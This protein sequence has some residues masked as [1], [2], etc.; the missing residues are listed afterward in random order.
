MNACRQFVCVL[1]LTVGASAYAQEQSLRPE[2]VL[3]A[4]YDH[5]PAILESLA[6]QRGAEA[7][8]LTAEGAFD[9]VFTGD[10]FSRVSGFYDGTVLTGG[11][12]RRLRSMGASVYANYRLSNGDFPIYEDVYFTNSGGE[13]R[14]GFLYSLL[15]DREIDPQRFGVRDAE[16][17]LE[18]AELDVM[19][20]RVGVQRQALIAYWRW[21]T[22]GR[23]LQVYENLLEIARNREA[24]LQ[25]EVD[26]GAR[27]AIF[28]TEN[29]QN[30]VRRQTLQTAAERDFRLATN[31]L[32][33]YYRDGGG[34]P[35]LPERDRLPPIG[36][37]SSNGE[38]LGSEEPISQALLRRPELTR[39]R[40]AIQRAQN[41][42]ALAENAQKPRLDLNVELD[43]DFGGIAEGGISRD[44]TDTKVG[45][46]FS[47]PLQLRQAR[48]QIDAANAEL[49]A[50]EQQQRFIEE[51]IEVEVGNILVSLDAAQSLLTLAEE[52]VVQS[53]TMQ[54]AEQRRFE[55][56][57][58]DFFLVNIREETAAN[59]RVLF[60]DA[61]L[62]REVARANYD[63]ATV[64]LPRLRI[65]DF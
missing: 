53:E 61:R 20:T 14:L 55:S 21:V 63:A 19:L 2:E 16:L 28:L 8:V 33:F 24:G 31:D 59:A 23:K 26:R 52:Q 51:Q 47:V 22:A 17:S 5:F 39:L 18:Q 40:A 6:R 11:A 37:L 44:A 54:A 56:G 7:E 30:I 45:F 13:V 25:R 57:A 41:R 27:A 64:N 32:S 1:L 58:S 50:L 36:S 9:L 48:G 43:H 38:E 34:D 15:R 42:R 3:A 29:L 62:E 65:T 4:S 35:V 60:H 10:G 49:M 46:T 12:E